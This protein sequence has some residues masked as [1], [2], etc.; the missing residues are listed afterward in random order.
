VRGTRSYARAVGWFGRAPFLA[1]AAASFV[2]ISVD[3]VRLLAIS[4]AY[5]RVP[6]V[7][8]TFVGRFP[9][10]L[11]LAVLGHELRPSNRAIVAVLVAMALVGLARWALHLARRG[12]GAGQGS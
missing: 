9:R 3:A 4:A 5:P 8:A 11:L 2:P 7:L 1:L 10:Y 6:Y 12:R